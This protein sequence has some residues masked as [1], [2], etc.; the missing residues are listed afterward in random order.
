MAEDLDVEAMLEAPYKKETVLN[1]E[2]SKTK[3]SEN[4]ENEMNVDQEQKIEEKENPENMENQENPE[5]PEKLIEKEKRHR[6][7]DRD[8]ER[9]R[10]RSSNHSHSHSHRR[11]HRS[12]SSHRSSRSHHRHRSSR[13]SRSSNRKHESRSHSHRSERK[14][15]RSYSERRSRSRS[16]RERSRDSEIVKMTEA[17]R[18]RRTVF[19]MQLSAKLRTSE[20]RSFFETVGKVSDVKII[21]DR[22]SRR[23][24][25]VGY[26]EF[27]EEASVDKALLL[28]N[29]TLLG[30][31][32]IVQRTESEKNR[33]EAGANQNNVTIPQNPIAATTAPV[34]NK[35]NTEAS[36][37]RL[38]VG[39]INFK[40]TEDD[41]KIL[42]K[43]FGELDFVKLHIN[44]ETG[45][46]CGYAFI[47]YK[48]AEDARKAL[49]I[50]NGYELA[51]RVIK[52]G[53]V[54]D[55][56]SNVM[57]LNLDDSDTV[58]FSLNSFTR[59]DLMQ[60]L[61]REGEL[62]ANPIAQQFPRVQNPTITKNVLLTNM[63]NPEEETEEGWEND[64]EEEVGSE[65]SK[66]GKI[67]SVVVNKNS[68]GFVYIKYESIT[69]AQ[70][71]IAALNGRF[72]AGKRI[73][74][75]FVIDAVFPQ[76]N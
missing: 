58:G 17:E 4:L 30:I 72:F 12:R 69:S 74:A 40:I 43:N 75:S 46:S 47:Q 13:R 29:K 61:S 19:V 53:L 52:V 56:T 44:P 34:E 18:D 37:K 54:S 6:S 68:K 41:L 16:P 38:Y 31:P 71:A 20:L 24:K 59:A 60:K 63:F 27:E 51:G 35:N 2:E 67:L 50:M 21:A 66:F 11:K 15:S 23:S 14:R 3:D 33:L 1:P 10:S 65:C 25:G 39:S 22:N 62:P 28:T 57:D 45:R 7:R 8:S 42:F 73:T 55:K 36:Y 32:I 5:N 48:R 9:H 70:A 26:V 64:I 76:K 49:D